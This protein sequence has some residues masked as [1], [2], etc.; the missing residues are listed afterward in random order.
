MDLDF[1]TVWIEVNWPAVGLLALALVGLAV[2]TVV[3]R[4]PHDDAPPERG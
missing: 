4:R 1:Q 3:R 2:F